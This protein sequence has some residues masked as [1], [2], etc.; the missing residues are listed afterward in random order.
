MP[1]VVGLPESEARGALDAQELDPVVTRDYSETVAAGTVVSAEVDPGTRLRHGTDVGLVVSQGPERYAVPRLDG[2]TLEQA[3]AALDEAHLRLGEQS[4]RHD[5]S[6]PAGQVISSS[7]AAGEQLKPGAAVAV[8][9]S[10]GPAP[11][12]VPDVSGKA[13]DQA[14]ALLQAAGLTVQVAPERVFDPEVPDGAVV[15]QSPGPSS[16]ARGTVVTV[17]VSK[18][19]EL[20]TVP[21][22]VGKQYRQ[23]ETMLAEL[24][25]TVRR[26][27]IAG[28]F[29]GTVREQSVEPGTEVPTGTEVVVRVV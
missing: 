11:V 24:G 3:S 2:S 9:L 19:P 16:V 26:E 8:V 21:D 18:G 22:L 7:P 12:D 20:V 27:D 14:S 13:Q 10:D 28:G 15:S 25:L 23:A 4:S 29:F 17:V 5:E 6:V 1:V